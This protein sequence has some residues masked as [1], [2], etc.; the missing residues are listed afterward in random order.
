MFINK[1]ESSF[2]LLSRNEDV[3]NKIQ[4]EILNTKHNEAKSRI[5]SELYNS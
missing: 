3:I 2:P 4:D 1:V 5:V